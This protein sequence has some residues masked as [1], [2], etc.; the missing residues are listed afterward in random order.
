MP[1]WCIY[2]HISLVDI[3][4]MAFNRKHELEER[5]AQEDDIYGIFM[6]YNNLDPLVEKICNH[7]AEQPMETRYKKVIETVRTSTH[8]IPKLAIILFAIWLCPEL[9]IGKNAHPRRFEPFEAGIQSICMNILK[10]KFLSV[11]EFVTNAITDYLVTPK[12]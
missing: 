5:E 2:W 1:N 11:Q 8:R 9:E 12:I 3:S 10:G 6:G 4:R 7:F